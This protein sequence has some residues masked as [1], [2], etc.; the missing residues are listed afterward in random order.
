M[1]HHIAAFEEEKDGFPSSCLVACEVGRKF[2]QED[3]AKG[4]ISRLSSC[5]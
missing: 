2:R 1:H 3:S 5:R 4:T